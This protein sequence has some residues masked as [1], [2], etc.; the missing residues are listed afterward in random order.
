MNIIKS[1]DKMIKI[2]SDIRGPLF[3]ESL[4][5]QKDGIDVLK[6]NTGNP[7]TF[8]FPLPESIQNA[9][10]GREAKGLENGTVLF[11]DSKPVNVSNPQRDR[12]RV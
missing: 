7:A 12:A 4:Q 1:A 8:G 6:L 5:M 10:T 9:L 3:M 11:H 2:H